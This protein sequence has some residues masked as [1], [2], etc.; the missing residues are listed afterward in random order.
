M[1]FRIRPL[2]R[3]YQTM[4]TLTCCCL[5]TL[6]GAV[7]LP[8][9]AVLADPQGILVEH[10]GTMPAGDGVVTGLLS[11]LTASTVTV[12]VEGQDRPQWVLTPVRP[13]EQPAPAP[14]VLAAEDAL[15]TAQ[16]ALGRAQSRRAL[17]EAALGGL[18]SATAALPDPQAQAA[19][20]S[21][22]ADQLAKAARDEAAALAG[23]ATAR[24]ALQAGGPPV[25]PLRWRLELTGADGRP[26]VVSY[27]LSG[28]AARLGYHLEVTGA[29]QRLTQVVDL[30]WPAVAASPPLAVTVV[31]RAAD[32]A[33]LVPAPVIR[34]LG[35]SEGVAGF[36]T[37]R[38][39][40]VSESYVN[41]ALTALL[42]QVRSDGSVGTTGWEVRATSLGLLSLS[43][44]GYDHKTPN[45]YRTTVGRMLSWLGAREP[46]TMSLVELAL[47]TMAVTDLHAMTGDAGIE[48]ATVRLQTTLQRRLAQNTELEAAM[49]RQGPLAGPEVLAYVAVAGKSMQA[50]QRT[51]GTAILERVR[52]LLPLLDRLQGDDEARA[53]SLVTRATLGDH[54]TDLTLADAQ[55]WVQR[56]PRWWQRGQL[57][58]IYLTTFAAFVSGGK[59]WQTWDAGHRDFLVEHQQN[60]GWQTAY[61]GDATVADA[62]LN[63]STEFYYRYNN[64]EGYQAKQTTSG[65]D[66]VPLVTDWPLRLAAPQAITLQPGR[67]RIAMVVIP[68]AG[69]QAWQAIPIQDRTVWRQLDATNPLATPLPAAPVTMMVD[70]ADV[71]RTDLPF[72]LPG[73]AFTLPLG[74]DPRLQAVRQATVTTDDGLTGRTLTLALRFTV[75][76]PAEFAGTVRVS[77]P[78]PMTGMSDLDW[79]GLEPAWSGKELA[80]QRSLDPAWHWPLARDGSATLR[81]QIRYPKR[82]RPFLEVLP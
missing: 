14:A 81:W 3:V 62:L 9:S 18:G 17:A 58:C 69:T 43:G 10:R 1:V 51:G 39:S 25:V 40:K 60:G 64:V 36:A 44:A 23:L 49:L 50:D 32:D 30:D 71:G 12:Q 80:K 54:L 45:R 66:T 38:R 65:R 19:Q 82:L 35:V 13:A 56:R 24:A 42:R 68:L 28:G 79:T 16:A 34:E 31:S 46:D 73:A 59:V 47:A 26:V 53:A 61:A 21:Y 4:R 76:A 6:A 74:A 72:T 27:R 20:A 37:P 77:E 75:L 7:D 8:P 29:Q 57:E 52:G 15:A 41:S 33:L 11:E 22:L 78:M 63:L 55:L 5:A 70:G 48:T 2:L 67:N